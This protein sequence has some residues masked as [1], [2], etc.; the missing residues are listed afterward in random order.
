MRT[1]SRSH[2]LEIVVQNRHFYNF[3]IIT[4]IVPLEHD[5]VR[6]AL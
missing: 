5:S 1:L 4:L 6:N 3:I 2:H